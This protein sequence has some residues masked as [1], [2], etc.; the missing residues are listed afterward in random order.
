MKMLPSGRKLKVV[1]VFLGLYLDKFALASGPVTAKC[2]KFGA[3]SP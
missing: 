3:N 2:E 1:F